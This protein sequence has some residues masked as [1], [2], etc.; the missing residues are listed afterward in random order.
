MIENSL[1]VIA[2]LAVLYAIIERYFVTS[3]TFFPYYLAF[4]L[5]LVGI[6]LF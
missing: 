6:L 3:P 4:S 2:A 5:F 1:F